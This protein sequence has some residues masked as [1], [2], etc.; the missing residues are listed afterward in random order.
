MD[1]GNL[2]IG[3]T[4]DKDNA[5][6]ELEQVGETVEKTGNKFAKIDKIVKM[7]MAGL[8]S[9]TVAITAFATKA[10]KDFTQTADNIDKMSQKLGISAE[11]YQE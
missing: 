4:V 3:I 5:V 7:G 9:A 1:L 11:A 2:R 10:V 8:A 6:K